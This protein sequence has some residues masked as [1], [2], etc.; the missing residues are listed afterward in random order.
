[1]H[2]LSGGKDCTTVCLFVNMQDKGN[3]CSVQCQRMNFYHSVNEGHE[4]NGHEGV[5][6]S[7]FIELVCMCA[8]TRRRKNSP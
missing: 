2:M 4:L 8:N 7:E 5:K 1:M 6:S 3:A